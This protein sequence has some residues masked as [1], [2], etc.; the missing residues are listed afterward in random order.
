MSAYVPLRLRAMDCGTVISRSITDGAPSRLPV[1]I[2]TVL[3]TSETST[4]PRRPVSPCTLTRFSVQPWTVIPPPKLLT[5]RL[6]PAGTA[7]VVSDCLCGASATS[8]AAAS[9][10]T[11]FVLLLGSS[12]GHVVHTPQQV[13]LAPH[14]IGEVEI[15]VRVAGVLLQRDARLSNG[16]ID[17]REVLPHDPH[18]GGVESFLILRQ[19]GLQLG[20]RRVSMSGPRDQLPH[21]GPRRGLAEA[22]LGRLR[23]SQGQPRAATRQKDQRD[24]RGHE[25]RD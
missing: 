8:I 17:D 24:A 9:V 11:M 1:L 19:R 14:R 7:K 20:D 6:A 12:R 10:A 22:Q 25:L 15:Q 4:R 23:R 3:P 21:A 13:H 2:T 18:G 5:E 16:P